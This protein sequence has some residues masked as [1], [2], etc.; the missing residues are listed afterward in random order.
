[1]VKKI[2]ELAMPVLATIAVI[3]AIKHVGFLAPVQNV[4]Q[5]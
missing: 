4:V 1:M 2:E 5:L 3:W